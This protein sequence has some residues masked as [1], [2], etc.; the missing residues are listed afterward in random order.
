MRVRGA[1]AA[2]ARRYRGPGSARPACPSERAAPKRRGY[3]HRIGRQR[4]PCLTM[5][6]QHLLPV[7]S[8]YTPSMS[9]PTCERCGY[10]IGGA[11]V[12]DQHRGGLD[13]S[14]AWRTRSGIARSIDTTGCRDAWHVTAPC[15]TCATAGRSTSPA[16]V[17]AAKPSM[18]TTAEWSVARGCRTTPRLHVRGAADLSSPFDLMPATA[19]R[20]V[21][22]QPTATVES[23]DSREAARVPPPI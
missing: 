15:W 13:A 19:Q 16:L 8:R 7:H 14:T 4:I 11:V 1:V 18:R 9:E 2:G 17:H 10:S 21:V 5:V 23:P 6:S 12:W 22:S 20:A 3:D